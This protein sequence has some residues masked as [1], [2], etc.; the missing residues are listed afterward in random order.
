M[1]DGLGR[2][3]SEAELKAMV[4][5]VDADGSGEIDFEEF[6]IIMARS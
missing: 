3:L 5:T 6:L 4:D 2:N 1:M